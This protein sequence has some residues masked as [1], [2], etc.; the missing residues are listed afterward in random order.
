[1]TWI[2]EIIVETS[3]LAAWWNACSRP[4]LTK[5]STLPLVENW[6]VLQ[7]EDGLLKGLSWIFGLSNLQRIT[8]I[9]I[10]TYIII[11]IFFWLAAHWSAHTQRQIA[12][13]NS[14]LCQTSCSDVCAHVSARHLR[15]SGSK[16]LQRVGCLFRNCVR[17]QN[18]EKSFCQ[19]LA[20]G[21]RILL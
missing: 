20:E 2:L 19:C 8:H 3:Q 7:N 11:L 10:N 18:G 21:W 4:K 17:G 5:V 14:G 15:A 6:S 9:Y 1:M 13:L 12:M 16:I